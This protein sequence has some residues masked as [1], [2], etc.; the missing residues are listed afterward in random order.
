MPNDNLQEKVLSSWI[1]LNALLKDSRVIK[2]MTY[3]EAVVMR[4]VLARY[5]EDGVGLTPLQ[6]IIRETH[7]LKS[8]VNRTVNA[9]CQQGYL[10]KSK[11]SRDGRNLLVQPIQ[12][13]LSEFLAVHRHSLRLAQRVIDII[14][15]EDAA[16][17]VRICEKLAEAE[18]ELS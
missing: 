2:S 14:G 7:M 3:N 1:G 15:E 17:F 16:H 6:Q 12:E 4:I 13:R 9:L 10:Q 11:D 8:Q 5:R 18:L